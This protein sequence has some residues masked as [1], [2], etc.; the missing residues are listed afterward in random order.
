M[1]VTI[2]IT[3]LAGFA[4]GTLGPSI[5]AAQSLCGAREA[6][7][8]M[9]GSRYGE[10]VRSV[11]LAGRDRIVEVFASEDTGSW[12]IV[13]TDTAGVTCLVASGQHYEQVA[14]GPEGAPL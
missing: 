13:V 2:L 9:L 11:G 12:T 7:V 10:T 8:D 4:C 3:A 5:A 1:K 6:V 14:A